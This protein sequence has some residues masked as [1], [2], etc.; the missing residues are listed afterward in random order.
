[1]KTVEEARKNGLVGNPVLAPVQISMVTQSVSTLL[2]AA[3]PAVV[4]V[5][6]FCR[7]ECV[8]PEKSVAANTT[9]ALLLVRSIMC[10][11]Q[12]ATGCGSTVNSSVLK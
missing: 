7:M 4:Q 11:L 1:M 5:T 10:L 12:N 8:W 3:G 2:G 9:T 6:W